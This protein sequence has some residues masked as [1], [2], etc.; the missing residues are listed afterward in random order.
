MAKVPLICRPGN[1]LVTG[2]LFTICSNGCLDS[3]LL[4]KF[5]GTSARAADQ[6][7][8]GFL[9][10]DKPRSLTRLMRFYKRIGDT[11]CTDCF[12]VFLIYH[13]KVREFVKVLGDHVFKSI[14]V[15]YGYCDFHFKSILWVPFRLLHFGDVGELEL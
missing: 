11:L 2:V 7:D 8:V 6:N 3:Q 13:N 5:D 9:F 15:F 10:V 12:A 14:V 1:F 4:E